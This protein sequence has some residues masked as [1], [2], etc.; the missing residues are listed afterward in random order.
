MKRSAALRAGGGLVAG[1][2][3][4]GVVTAA[5]ATAHDIRPTHVS[6][7]DQGTRI[8]A[9]RAAAAGIDWRDCPADTGLTAPVQCGRVTVPLDYAQ[10]DGRTIT[11]TVDRIANTGGPAERQGALLH[12]PGGPGASGLLF[13]TQVSNGDPIWARAARAYDFVGFDPRGVGYSGLFSCQDPGEFAGTP[14]PD[15]VPHSEADKTA[16]RKLARSYAEGCRIRGGD[17]LPFL[18]TENTARDLE[19]IRA[20]LGEKQL[21]YVGVSYGGYLGAVYA[22][23]FPRHVRRMIADSSVDPS[24]AKLGYRANLEQNLG[25]QRRWQDWTAWVAR[26]DATYHLGDTAAAV[27]AGWEKLRADVKAHPLGGTVGPAELTTLFQNALYY[28]T[29]WA[30]LASIWS[31]HR[32]G[33][34]TLLVAAATQATN[35]I[36]AENA[37]AVY[38]AV[39]C[40]DN[41]WPIDW[42]TWDRDATRLHRQAPFMTWANTWKNLPCATWPIRTNT[43]VDVR[44]GGGL[45]PVLIVHSTRDAAAP[46]SGAVELHNRL[47]GSRL[48][49]NSDAGSHG[50]T[51]LVNPCVNQRVD[52]YLLT[53]RLDSRNV[54]CAPHGQEPNAVSTGR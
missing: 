31:S 53:G 22:T 46:Y 23:L 15:P 37:N 28:D 24:R 7:V 39:G 32:V 36:A 43:P 34:D 54:V 3:V 29:V 10:P 44:S 16:Q 5:P 12:N 40:N 1:A 35:A 42:T 52:A 2:L 18:S 25:F 30:P 47:E 33:D 41:A 4:A 11:L 8:A 21:N 19:V 48:I 45:P 38:T 26:H 50:V 20:A 6:A 27:Q 9:E 13:P 17:L 51:D 14:K 49:T